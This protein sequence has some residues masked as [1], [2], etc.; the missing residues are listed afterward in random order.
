M[1]AK[2]ISPAARLSQ[3]GFC[4]HKITSC[5][6]KDRNKKTRYESIR[7]KAALYFRKNRPMKEL[8]FD[9][10]RRIRLKASGQLTHVCREIPSLQAR[11]NKERQVKRILITIFIYNEY[12]SVIYYDITN[13]RY[14]VILFK[15]TFEHLN[16]CTFV[17]SNIITYFTTNIITL[18]IS[19]VC[20]YFISYVH[21]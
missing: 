1:W 19:N 10:Q 5:V 3:V 11:R 7:L 20:Y 15:C 4:A 12:N 18:F 14:Y 13:V 21:Y 16:I 17:C 6:Y 8:R 2:R 9:V